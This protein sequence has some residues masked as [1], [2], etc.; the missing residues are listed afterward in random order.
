M[1]I[2]ATRELTKLAEQDFVTNKRFSFSRSKKKKTVTQLGYDFF[3]ARTMGNNVHKENMD[4]KK[5]LTN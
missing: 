2:Q 4:S 1:K 3:C 5:F